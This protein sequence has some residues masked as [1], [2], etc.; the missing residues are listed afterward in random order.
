[1]RASGR[2]GHQIRPISLRP[3][4]PPESVIDSE[5]TSMATRTRF[6]T[7]DPTS[8]EAV[9]R[10][11]RGL[12]TSPGYCLHQLHGTG[13]VKGCCVVPDDTAKRRTGRAGPWCYLELE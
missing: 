7:S 6:V 3:P 12:F 5:Q 8:G 2:R 13:P 4:L 1:M 11:D 10:A 9:A